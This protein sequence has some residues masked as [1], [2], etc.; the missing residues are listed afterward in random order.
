MEEMLNDSWITLENVA[1]YLGVK[2]KAVRS[3][4]KRTYIPVY[5]TGRCGS[6]LKK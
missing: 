3:L 6:F 5:K 2:E 1:N 4:I